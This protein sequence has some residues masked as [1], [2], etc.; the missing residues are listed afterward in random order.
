M[1]G[2]RDCMKQNVIQD[3]QENLVDQ[4]LTHY[5][6]QKHKL[7]MLGGYHNQV[8]SINHHEHEYVI[9]VTERM[10]RSYDELKGE[11]EFVTYLRNQ[12]VP[13]YSVIDLKKMTT[14][15]NTYYITL[16]DKALG[17]RWYE[18]LLDDHI[19]FE[20]GKLL[21]KIHS[22]SKKLKKVLHRKPFNQNHYIRNSKFYLDKVIRKHLEEVVELIEAIPK[23]QENYGLIHGDYHFANLIYGENNLM[24]IDFDDCEYHF[25]IYDIAV[26]L[27]YYILGSDPT[28]INLETSKR[29]FCAFIKGYM[30]ENSISLEMLEKLPLFLRLRELKLLVSILQ[31]VDKQITAWGK[32]YIKRTKQ[33]LF[34]NR[35]FVES[36]YTELFKQTV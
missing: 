31:D 3:I 18:M 35:P 7:I 2:D 25:F 9:R 23:N 27:F 15:Q 12:G 17:K 11:L 30:L 21:G 1:K 19:Y 10:H 24:V 13:V 8:Y 34:Q 22:K 32:N 6:F 14:N 16:F 5:H 33:N 20:A 28:H 29:V 4:I 26:Y 36:D